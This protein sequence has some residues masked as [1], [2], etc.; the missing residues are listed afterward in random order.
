VETFHKRQIFI[1][2]YSWAPDNRV[3]KSLLW[4]ECYELTGGWRKLYNEDLHNLYSLLDIV[5]VLK[6]RRVEGERTSFVES[7]ISVLR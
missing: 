6:S 2:P 1:Q 3:L 4:S 7:D 5:M